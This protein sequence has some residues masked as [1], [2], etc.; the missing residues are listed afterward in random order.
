MPLWQISLAL[1][2]ALLL[3]YLLGEPRRFHPL[4]GLGRIITK[5]E[6]RLNNDS[7]LFGVAALALLVLP[8]LV[9][10]LLELPL[11]LQII[12]LYLVIGGRSLTEHGTAVAL[13]LA[14]GTIEDAR[15]KVSYIVSR[16]T[17]SLD[18]PK[19]VSATVESMLENGND[20]VFGALF[21][22]IVGGA[23]AAIIYRIAN[24]LDARWGYR[25][26]RFNQFGWAAAKFDDLLNWLPARLTVLTYAAQGNFRQSLRCAWL[27]GRQCASPNGGPVMA[28][29]AGAMNVTIGGGAEY[30]GYRCDKPLL[31][32]GTYADASAIRKACALVDY[33]AWAW[34]GG[35]A[36]LC[37]VLY[38]ITGTLV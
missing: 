30:D 36:L 14:S 4:V 12:I 23:P 35:L 7:K 20:A 2:M 29:G 10:Y 27:Q 26:E 34:A 19:V 8:C 9:L 3:D 11:W 25:N 6:A 15:T 18:E 28:A 38:F 17:D 16:K 31:G 33:G 24:T 21:W 5:V 32:V 22:F 1:M 13:A 37:I